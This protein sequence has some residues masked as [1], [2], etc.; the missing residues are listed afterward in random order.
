M[1]L[2]R[3]LANERSIYGLQGQ[4]LEA[5]QDPH[6]RIEEHP[7]DDIAGPRGQVVRALSAS[8]VRYQLGVTKR[9]RR[10]GPLLTGR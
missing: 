10:R 7:E 9:L 4:G 2:A 3:Q 8:R 5:G 1:P 6:E